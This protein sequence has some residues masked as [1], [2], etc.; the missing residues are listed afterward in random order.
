MET[1]PE[2]GIEAYDAGAAKLQAF[3]HEHLKKYLQPEL[4]QNARD[5]IECCLEGGSVVEYKKF[6]PEAKISI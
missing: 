6:I 5:I 3:F 2:V 4:S 1:Q